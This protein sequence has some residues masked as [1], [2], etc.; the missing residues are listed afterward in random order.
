M[1]KKNAFNHL[2]PFIICG[3][4]GIFL[5]YEFILQVSPSVMTQG[6]MQSFGINAMTLGSA[7]AMYYYS[8]APMQL[9]SGLS[10]D[11]FGAKKTLTIAILACGFGTMM[12]AWS[13]SIY[14]A[15]LGRFLTGLG[16]SC[17]FIGV[18]FLGERWFHPKYFFLVAGITELLGCLGA[19]SGQIPVASAVHHFGWRNTLW[20]L[21]FF[22]FILAAFVWF[23][24]HE[25]KNDKPTEHATLPKQLGVKDS[26][27]YVL[28]NTQSWAVGLYA[29]CV[30]APITMFA[31]LWGVPFLV[32]KYNISTPL[33]GSACA[34]IWLGM[35]I[36]SPI[37]GWVSEL[38][39][40]RK[41]P[42]GFCAIIG[43]IIT[44]IIIYT[45]GIP[46]DLMFVLLFIFG[47]A[48][49]GQSLSFNVI[50]D[51][52]PSN[53]IGTAMGFNNMLIVFSGA[54]LQPLIGT[55]IS[56]LW[57]GQMQ[58]GVPHYTLAN[59]QY[60]FVLIPLFYF[61]GF[62]INQFWLKETSCK[63]ISMQIEGNQYLSKV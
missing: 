25:G 3:F 42:L 24:V 2:V 11:H 55:I 35:G 34:M 33:A 54:L 48:T 44:F 9:F 45:P 8:Y 59:Y 1:T 39:F 61:L 41:I 51:N 22:G 14:I 47:V 6:L 57:N 40:S 13:H 62:L 7:M 17:A 29:F 16:S 23:I 43:V 32:E 19:I 58:N 56:Y 52:M 28:K 4:A 15:G 53:V 21:A 60:A 10:F 30:F 36:G 50:N 26:L 46:L 49:S 18:L 27:K 63:N 37:A 5:V 38:L 12:I 31:A 20:F